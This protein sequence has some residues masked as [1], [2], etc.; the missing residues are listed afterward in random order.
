MPAVP[1][2]DCDSF[3]AKLICKLIGVF[4]VAGRGFFSEIY[5]FTYGGIT[6]LLEGGLHTD[7]PFGLNI[8]GAFEDTP[9]FGRD[10]G[11]GLYAADF[12]DFL[13]QTVVVKPLFFSELFEDGI[14]L[15][16]FF[17]V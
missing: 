12:G 6:V 9:D 11:K 1:A 16:H 8:V 17:A 13:L 4:H 2:V 10:F 7:V 3:A 5:G 15:K 14:Y